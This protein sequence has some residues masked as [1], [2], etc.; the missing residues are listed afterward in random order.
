MRIALNWFE[1]ALP[2]PQ[3]G[4]QVEVLQAD[5]PADAQRR[6]HYPHRTLQRRDGWTVRYLHLT[7]KPVAD[8]PIESLE[9]R[10]D[11]NF[12]KQAI[13][14][15]F[16]EALAAKAFE[17][18]T[19][20]IGG[21]GYLVTSD[22]LFPD[23]YSLLRGMSYRAFF[24]FG[25]PSPRWGLILNY[26]TSQRFSL[27]LQHP[28]LRAMAIG[29]RV[30]PLSSAAVSAD[31]DE[32]HP[33]SGILMTLERDMATISTSSGDVIQEAADRWT[34]PCRR[35]T[36][37]ELVRRIHGTSAAAQVMRHLQQFTFAITSSG[38][39]NTALA[40]NQ[41]GAVQSLLRSHDLLRF[42]LPLPSRPPV[43]LSDHPTV[44]MK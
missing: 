19:Y 39:M 22:S 20:H 6:A 1:V 40:K 34:V 3:L 13:E 14:I 33:G 12:V 8:L 37:Q 4:V 23:V 41:L 27:S 16:A 11:P 9:V 31:D 43:S 26:A 2:K 30:V 32:E 24:G 25:G 42:S 35:E 5:A 44:V 28:E 29:R 18:H 10:T 7:D 17:V 15:G 36:L 38:R 21:R